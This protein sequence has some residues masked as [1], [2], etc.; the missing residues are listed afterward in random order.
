MI[1]IIKMD[2]YRVLK[3][4][5]TYILL[6]AVVIFS[7]ISMGSFILLELTVKYMD[8]DALGADTMSILMSTMPKNLDGYFEMF[9][10]GNFGIVF[11]VLFAILFCSAEYK[12][13]YIKNT[14]VNILPR[15]LTY[16]SKLIIVTVFSIITFGLIFLIVLG[17]CKI[18]GVNEIVSKKAIAKMI[19]VQLLLNISLTSFIM[20][21][22]YLTRKA[23]IA[24]IS[25]LLYATMGNL[26]YALINV[27]IS[28]ALPNSDF[29]LS[30]YTNLGN[31]VF[32]I[33][34]SASISGCVRAIIVAIVFIAI[35]SVFSCIAINKKDIT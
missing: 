25:G 10:F 29:D 32:H 27:L 20:M 30:K 8:T 15:H 17:G 14:A 12:T 35:S 28:V 18:A 26:V 19:F 33:N 2:T 4:K 7:L 24:M 22:Y 16:F 9:F 5:L 6:G 1:N 13:G 31:M 34:T 3:N 11:L 21:I 23:V